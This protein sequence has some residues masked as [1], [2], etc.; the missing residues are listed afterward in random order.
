VYLAAGLLVLG[1]GVY[2]STK[3]WAQGSTPAAQTRVG[4]VNMAYVLKNYKKVEALSAEMKKYIT[5]CEAYRK[6]HRDDIEKLTKAVQDPAQAPN[7]DANDKKIKQLQREMEDVNTD[8]QKYLNQRGEEQTVI[9]Y[10]EI[11]EAVKVYAGPH[12]LDMV[13][14][15]YDVPDQSDPAMVNR[16][17]MTKMQQPACMPM[18]FNPSMDVSAAIVQM[19]NANYKPPAQPATTPT[20]TGTPTTPP[21]SH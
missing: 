4:V 8:M 3:L 10:R 15:Y 18:Y 17:M 14:T 7:R 19:L 20:G 13:L 11:Q 1:A 9:L 6:G 21:A 12:N 5:E 2:F 16:S